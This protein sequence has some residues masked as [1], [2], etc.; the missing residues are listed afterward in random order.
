M[1]AKTLAFIHF[2]PPAQAVAAAEPACFEEMYNAHFDFVFRSAR[3]L[4]V[5]EASLDDVVQRVFLVAYQRLA[6]FER[7]SSL[8]TWLFGILLNAARDERRTQR[9]K[10][11]HWFA[12]PIDPDTLS[13]ATYAPD[14]ALERTEAARTV[15]ALLESL[16]GDKRV[17]F[18][19]AELEQMSAAEISEAT[20]LGTNAVYSRLRAARIDFERAVV[21]LRRRRAAEEKAT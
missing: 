6:A 19:M 17:V 3:R 21:K 4:G 1:L 5:P 16:K 8:K 12:P 18:V 14:G 9:R 7:R 10:F 20:G 11:P 15:D 2:A 13:D